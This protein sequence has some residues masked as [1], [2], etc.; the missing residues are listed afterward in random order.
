[1]PQPFPPR[2]LSVLRF[3]KSL[4]NPSPVNGFDYIEVNSAI[5]MKRK[6]LF[7]TLAV[8]LELLAIIVV[9]ASWSLT[10]GIVLIIAGLI[11]LILGVVLKKL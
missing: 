9:K 7:L 8:V 6:N 3:P 5:A 4:K 11:A 2:N 10:A 1:M